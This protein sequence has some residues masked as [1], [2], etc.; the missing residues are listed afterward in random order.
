MNTQAALLLYR[1]YIGQCADL[2]KKPEIEYMKSVALEL[3]GVD[4][5]YALLGRNIFSLYEYMKKSRTSRSFPY[6]FLSFYELYLRS[7][8]ALRSESRG[9]K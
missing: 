3:H 8:V 6:S 4:Y 2:G 7:Q 5:L 1:M 9:K